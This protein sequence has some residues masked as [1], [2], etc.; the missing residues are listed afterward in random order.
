MPFHH[1]DALGLVWHGHYPKYF[2][3]AGMALGNIAIQLGTRELLLG[4]DPQLRA[5]ELDS[6]SPE[7]LAEIIARSLDPSRSIVTTVEPANGKK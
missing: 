3:A 4:A 6:L 5:R 1:V 2:A 7:S